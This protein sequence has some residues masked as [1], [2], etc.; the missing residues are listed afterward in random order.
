MNRVH[1]YAYLDPGPHISL[2][3]FIKREADWVGVDED[4][5]NAIYAACAP[6][7]RQ[8][9]GHG[10]NGAFSAACCPAYLILLLRWSGPRRNTGNMETTL[11]WRQNTSCSYTGIELYVEGMRP[12]DLL[13]VIKHDEWMK[14]LMGPNNLQTQSRCQQFAPLDHS[15]SAGRGESTKMPTG[16]GGTYVIAAIVLA[17]LSRVGLVI[18]VA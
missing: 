7:R 16:Q 9:V 3:H 13:K 14:T 8:G 1:R 6:N 17:V 11:I 12:W 18:F 15:P 2:N 10:E 4:A 5:A